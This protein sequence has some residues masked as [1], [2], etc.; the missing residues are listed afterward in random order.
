VLF[1]RDGIVGD[2]VVRILARALFPNPPA[3]P[4]PSPASPSVP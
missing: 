1:N 2:D 4:A 3:T